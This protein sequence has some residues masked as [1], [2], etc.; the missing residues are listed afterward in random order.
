M[1]PGL[2]QYLKEKGAT[3]VALE[4]LEN[5]RKEMDIVMPQISKAIRKR[6]MTAAK[7]ICGIRGIN[8]D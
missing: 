2:K 7:L 4:I 8:N 3:K 1:S 5:Y 6:E